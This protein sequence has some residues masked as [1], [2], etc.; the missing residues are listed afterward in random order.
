[1]AA[2]NKSGKVRARSYEGFSSHVR[3]GPE[4]IYEINNIFFLRRFRASV[5]VGDA[6]EKI[7]REGWTSTG[8]GKTHKAA[9]VSSVMRTGDFSFRACEC[10]RK[11]NVLPSFLSASVSS[12]QYA[13]DVHL[14][15]CEWVDAWVAQVTTDVT[16]QPSG[17]CLSS[18]LTHVGERISLYNETIPP[19]PFPNQFCPSFLKL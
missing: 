11:M 16:G 19:P 9:Y 12:S 7:R 8:R 14:F 18:P 6:T 3:H 13:T 2:I 5:A 4:L 15:T 1:M 17:Q 10:K